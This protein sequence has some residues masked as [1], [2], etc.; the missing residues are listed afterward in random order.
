MYEQIAHFGGRKVSS[1]GI[2]EKEKDDSTHS[3]LTIPFSPPLSPK[4]DAWGIWWVLT[5]DK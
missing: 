2:S 4:E 1:D 3:L 5:V